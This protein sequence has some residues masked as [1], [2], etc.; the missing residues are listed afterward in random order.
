MESPMKKDPRSPAAA[1]SD[2]PGDNPDE[3]GATHPE[4]SRLVD[5][6]EERLSSTV[7][8]SVRSHLGTCEPCAATVAAFAHLVQTLHAERADRP[9]A[10]LSD[11]ARALPDTV[12]LGR[13]AVRPGAIRPGG[14]G[15]TIRRG[16][17]AAGAGALRLVADSWALVSE[18]LTPAPA[19]RSGDAR[20]TSLGR[21]RL[22]FSARPFDLDLE[23]DYSGQTDPRRLHGQ[24]L[25]LEGPRADWQ[26]SEV[27]LTAAGRTVSRA[28][29]D[30]RGEF[31]LFRVQPGRYRLEIRPLAIRRPGAP[32]RAAD[33][34]RC[35]SPVIEV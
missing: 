2:S 26:G 23:V 9:P 8:R 27:L 31:R 7:A 11:W 18:G 35:A 32:A 34:G 25:P 3:S 16:L 14:V 30:R 33:A 5:L 4:P 13:R 17:A 21:R 19:L 15:A 24:I 22:L 10:A 20:A 6:V 28:R 1:R 12:S 29:I